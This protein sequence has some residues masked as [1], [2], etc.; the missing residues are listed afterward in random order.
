VKENIELN[1][2]DSEA[3]R[4]MNPPSLPNQIRSTAGAVPVL[5]KKGESR[6]AG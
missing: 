4:K 5:N 2:L 6:V 3:W 1:Y